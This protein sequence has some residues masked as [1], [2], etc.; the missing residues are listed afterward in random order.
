MTRPGGS[1]PAS[2]IFNV[3]RRQ[4]KLKVRV[5]IDIF[6]F[7]NSNLVT[8]SVLANPATMVPK[9]MVSKLEVLIKHLAVC[10]AVGED[11][12]S[13]GALLK[14][15]RHPSKLSGRDKENGHYT[16]TPGRSL[17]GHAGSLPFSGSSTPTSAPPGTPGSFWGGGRLAR[18][19]TQ[20]IG[21]SSAQSTPR[22]LSSA[23]SSSTTSRAPG[24]RR[25]SES[26]YT[27]YLGIGDDPYAFPPRLS[28]E[29]QADYCKLLLSGNC[30]FRL[31]EL[32]YWQ[33]FFR[34][35]IPGAPAPSRFTLSGRILDEEAARVL[36]GMK[37]HLQGR[38]GTGQSDGW[39]TIT[40]ASIIASMVNAEYEASATLLDRRFCS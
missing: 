27:S 11:V 4:F 40:K 6:H 36:D 31:A 35:W 29:Y 9:P 15:H 22:A 18:T 28:A 19:D 39:K 26:T 7:Q 32:P 37:L 34:K 23:S 20:L 24:K 13:H 10:Q 5:Q 38:Y 14:E 12:S 25:L 3:P 30:A 8:G 17:L 1:P 2:S 21:R 16:G 33:H